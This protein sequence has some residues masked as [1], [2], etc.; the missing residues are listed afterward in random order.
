MAE[1][2][3]ARRKYKPRKPLNKKGSAP[4]RLPPG[5][6]HPIDIHV[7]DRLRQRRTILGLTQEKL[8]E[9]V[10]LTF[11]QIQKYERGA[12]RI[13]ASRL[14]QFSQLLGISI[15][16]FFDGLDQKMGDPAEGYRLGIDYRD[17]EPPER[18]EMNRRET[19]ELVRAY[20]RIVDPEKREAL[21][22]M[23]QALA[24]AAKNK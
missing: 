15:N 13:G 19:L 24:G 2:R 3:Q 23:F 5:V 7:G 17:N 8:A 9:S 10:G 11:Q 18:D 12:N 6:A 14:F 1:K 20:Y 16:F 4:V 21:M 22:S